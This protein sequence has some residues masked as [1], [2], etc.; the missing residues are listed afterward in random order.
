MQSSAPSEACSR[1]INY[2]VFLKDI[3]GTIVNQS[4]VSSD[5]C[6]NGSCSLMLITPEFICRAEIIASNELGESNIT[7]ANVG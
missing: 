4:K 6:E 7:S 1:A 3:T 2:T 5:S